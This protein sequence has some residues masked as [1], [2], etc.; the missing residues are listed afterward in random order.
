MEIFMTT[1]TAQCPSRFGMPTGGHLS[2]VILGATVA[3]I[4]GTTV[5]AAD[6]GAWAA[7]VRDRGAI[8]SVKGFGTTFAYLPGPLAWRPPTC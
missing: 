6:Q 4:Q 5:S 8:A 7:D 3:P 2:Q 1:T